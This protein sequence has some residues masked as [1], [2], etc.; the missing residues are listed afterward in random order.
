MTTATRKLTIRSGFALF[1]KEWP[2]NWEASPF[3][4]DGKQYNCVEQWMMAEKARFFKD[5]EVRKEILATSDPKTQK[6]LGRKVRDYDDRLWSKVRFDIV[7]R[8]T[9][10]KYEQNP[11]LKELLLSVPDGTRFVE[12]S[13]F[14]K[15]WGI[16]MSQNDP[17]ATDPSLWLGQNLLGYAIDDALRIIRLRTV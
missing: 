2:S 6:A 4:L 11:H 16:G 13:P 14:D 3:A 17:R 7:V 15:V 10:E 12:A 5:E 1:W 8:G 9:I